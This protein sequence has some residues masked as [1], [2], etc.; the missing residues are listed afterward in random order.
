MLDKNKYLSIYVR[1]SSTKLYPTRTVF[2]RKKKTEET[3]QYTRTKVV[4]ENAFIT[5]KGRKTLGHE[6]PFAIQASEKR[7]FQRSFTEAN[8]GPG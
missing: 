8:P 7:L 4:N 3:T 1:R 6:G 5:R 2:S